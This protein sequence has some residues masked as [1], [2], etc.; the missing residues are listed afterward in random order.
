MV[1]YDP[2]VT[3]FSKMLDIGTSLSVEGLTAQRLY[4]TFV[5]HQRSRE[6]NQKILERKREELYKLA[7]LNVELLEQALR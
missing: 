2:K 3:A 5:E 7:M 6:R 1:S 4:D